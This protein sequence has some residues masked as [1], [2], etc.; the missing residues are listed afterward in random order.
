M[1]SRDLSK[2][3][4]KMREFAKKF[5]AECSR[6]GIHIEITCVSRDIYEQTALYAQGRKTLS[7]V[8]SLRKIAGLFPISAKENTYCVTWTLK[9]LHVVNP[10]NEQ[11][12]DDLS[13][14]I[15]FVVVKGKDYTWDLKADIN[16]NNIPDYEEIGKIA[17]EVDS[18]IVWGGTFKNKD[19]PHFQEGA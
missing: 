12:G 4:P 8:N 10:H 6:R 14:A 18:S 7:E 11:V 1:S 19:Y 5:I 13:R 17:K 9:S 2:A 15:D 16:K 3:T